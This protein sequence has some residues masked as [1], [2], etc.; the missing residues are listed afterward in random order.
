MVSSG[1]YENNA[2]DKWAIEGNYSYMIPNSSKAI[3]ISL[4]DRGLTG[5]LDVKVPKVI[6]KN[7]KCPNS[8]KGKGQKE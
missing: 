5:T 2:K 1:E 7:L 4:M 6:Q 8:H 3:T